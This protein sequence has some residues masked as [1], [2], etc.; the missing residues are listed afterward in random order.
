MASRASSKSG[1]TLMPTVKAQLRMMTTSRNRWRYRFYQQPHRTAEKLINELQW[2]SKEN[3]EVWVQARKLADEAR[4]L[5]KE[6]EELKAK[7]Q[8]GERHGRSKT[9]K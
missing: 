4:R 5:M 6:N 1:S 8:Q 3:A 2:L 9:G 7:L